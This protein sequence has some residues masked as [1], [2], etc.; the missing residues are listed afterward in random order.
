MDDLVG[1]MHTQVNMKDRNLNE[2][3]ADESFLNVESPTVQC[4][5]LY[6]MECRIEYA[7]HEIDRRSRVT[8]RL[9]FVV[10]FV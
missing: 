6:K 9:V 10:N 5:Q 8:V 3:E 1:L 2:F 7:I 4:H